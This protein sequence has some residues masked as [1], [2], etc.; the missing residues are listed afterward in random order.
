[1]SIPSSITLEILTPDKPIVH[2]QV[3]EVLLPA[4][5]GAIGVLP[6][7]TP[8][9]AMLKPG[10]LWYRTGSLKTTLVIDFGT[11]EVLPDRVSVLITLAERPEDIDPARQ[12]AAR[13]QAEQEMKQAVSLEDAERARVA[14]L[15]ALIKLRAAEQ[16]RAKR[17]V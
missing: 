4:A 15:T 16:V 7:H 13:Q 5:N 9:L 17:G 8:L 11:A 6:G 2:E 1:M 14:L 10:E 12:Q 3:D